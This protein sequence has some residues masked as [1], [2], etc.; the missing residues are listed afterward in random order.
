LEEC[1]WPLFGE[2]FAECSI[3]GAV[4]RERIVPD[5]RRAVLV[6]DFKR[7]A[8]MRGDPNDVDGQADAIL[9]EGPA[10]GRLD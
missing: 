1:L 9:L 6:D 3:S 7:P 4:S 2:Y 10:K 5:D 8:R